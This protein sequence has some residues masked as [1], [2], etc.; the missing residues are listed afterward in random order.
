MW[1]VIAKN[2]FVYYI[3]YAVGMKYVYGSL[4]AIPI[5]IIWIYI[6]WIFVLFGCELAYVVQNFRSLSIGEARKNDSVDQHT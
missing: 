6:T 4:A 3:R 5:F 1:H 2:A